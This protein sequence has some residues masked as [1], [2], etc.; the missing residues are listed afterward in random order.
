[1]TPPL[2]ICALCVE[3]FDAVFVWCPEARSSQEA[4]INFIILCCL[5]LDQF[6]LWQLRL[7]TFKLRTVKKKQYSG[8]FLHTYWCCQLSSITLCNLKFGKFLEHQRTFSGTCT[9]NIFNVIFTVFKC[10]RL[11]T[12]VSLYGLHLIAAPS[13]AE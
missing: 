13:T 6:C 9:A 10:V 1:M 8:F 11:S 4:S 2:A 12:V 3:L 5:L 7:W